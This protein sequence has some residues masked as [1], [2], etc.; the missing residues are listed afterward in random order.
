MSFIYP[1]WDS[2]REILNVT[3]NSF[4]VRE[5]YENQDCNKRST[6]L[7]GEYQKDCKAIINKNKIPPQE[8]VA[9][10]F[11]LKEKGAYIE[12]I[13]T[14]GMYY[15]EK[16]YA[17]IVSE[18]VSVNRDYNP[19]YWQQEYDAQAKAVA[20]AEAEGYHIF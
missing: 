11:V 19:E 9:T 18:K 1:H 5:Y 10:P 4:T 7:L 17:V 3:P 6:K 16:E 13:L 2:D 14:N 20:M 15:L 12:S 8:F